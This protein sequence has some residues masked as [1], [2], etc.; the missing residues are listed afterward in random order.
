LALWEPD[1][2]F[3]LGDWD[4]VIYGSE[5]VFKK[6]LEQHKEKPEVQEYLRFQEKYNKSGSPVSFEF[7]VLEIEK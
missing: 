7:R 1:K 6:V 4:K 3:V 5:D 2:R